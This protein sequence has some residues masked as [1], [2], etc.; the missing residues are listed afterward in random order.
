MEQPKHQTNSERTLRVGH[1]GACGYEPE[2]TI[3]SFER[4]IALGAD[5]VELDVHVCQTGEPIVIHDETVDRTTDG[6]GQVARMTLAEIRQLRISGSE[7]IPTLQEVLEVTHG[8]C[9]VNVEVKKKIAARAALEAIAAADAYATTMVSSNYVEPLRAAKQADH[10]LTTALI[11]YSTKTDARDVLFA[12]LCLAALPIALRVILKRARQAGAD[13]VN[14]MKQLATP[15][16]I[17][18]LHSH[19]L[20]V[21]IWTVNEPDE[22]KEIASRHVDALLSNYPDRLPR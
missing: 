16:I 5:M 4:A 21:G 6:H 2:N 20:Q 11:F 3:R 1:R 17:T 15:S 18:A 22:I 12:Y 7:T 13:W 19:H 9:R 14:L 10:R 8:R